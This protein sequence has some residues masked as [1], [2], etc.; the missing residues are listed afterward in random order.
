MEN[1]L[2]VS[3]IYPWTKVWDLF[4][5][6]ERW[7][8]NPKKNYVD[9]RYVADAI[10]EE[11]IERWRTTYSN[12]IAHKYEEIDYSPI[13]YLSLDYIKPCTLKYYYPVFMSA[14]TGKGKNYFVT[15]VLRKYAREKHLHILYLSNRTAL[16]YQQ[17]K[18]LALLCGKHLCPEMDDKW[19][20]ECE[21]GN[22]TVLTYHKLLSYLKTPGGKRTFD[23]VVLDECHF[24]YSDAFFNPDT[25]WLLETIVETFARSIRIYMSG[26]ME[27]IYEPIRYFEGRLPLQLLANNNEEHN[28]KALENMID[29]NPFY[30]EF[31]KD[32]APYEIK[33]FDAKKL[34]DALET[35]E[36]D[37]FAKEGYWELL[38]KVCCSKSEKTLIFVS[39]KKTG[40]NLKKGL[41]A[42]SK[43]NG[44]KNT[45][46]PLVSYIDRDSRSGNNKA[47]YEAWTTL[48]EEGKFKSRILIATSV[49]DNGFSIK[50]DKLENIVLFTDDRTE[51]LQELGRCRLNKDRRLNLY[52]KITSQEDISRLKQKY[53]EYYAVVARCIK[54]EA[55]LL[56]EDLYYDGFVDETACFQSLWND[57]RDTRRNFFSI[58]RQSV[59]ERS[60]IEVKFN[61]MVRWSLRKMGESILTYNRYA[62]EAEDI[63]GILFKAD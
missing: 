24:F 28:K 50:D 23:F 60:M 6:G 59:G 7:H 47:E 4:E 43:A 45:E 30:Y 44:V 16:D 63:A 49:L 57:D 62:E 12:W 22:I 9:S 21:F 19:K 3:V 33:F 61:P 37:D 53:D 29:G 26:T 55:Y 27:E 58:S 35:E 46:E 34:M 8:P 15:H 14:Q 2:G 39:D 56:N 40:K 52:V 36:T 54:E 38:H 41:E 10:T 13:S 48:I 1:S 17:K 20:D 11:T 5:G 25:W 18:E 32:Y 31:K 51:F 42:F